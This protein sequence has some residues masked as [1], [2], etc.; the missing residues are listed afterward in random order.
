MTRNLRAGNANQRERAQ[1]ALAGGVLF[2]LYNRTLRI[3]QAIEW[4]T[5]KGRALLGNLTREY[6][7]TS[8][9]HMETIRVS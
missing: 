8:L 6:Y 4:S 3:L 7:G 1:N 2:A 5:L 9:L